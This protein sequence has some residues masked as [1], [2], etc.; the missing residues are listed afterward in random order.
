LD[1]AL[2]LSLAVNP[3]FSLSAALQR[4]IEFGVLSQMTFFQSTP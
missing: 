2:E 1:E 3:Q 4:C